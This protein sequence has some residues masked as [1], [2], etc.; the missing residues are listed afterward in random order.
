MKLS[1]VLVLLA[2]GASHGYR[3]TVKE[4][5]AKDSGENVTEGDEE[6]SGLAK[7]MVELLRKV[8]TLRKLGNAIPRIKT[9]IWGVVQKAITWIQ[10][11]AQVVAKDVKNPMAKIAQSTVRI[12]KRLKRQVLRIKDDAAYSKQIDNELDE[13]TAEE[14]FGMIKK[15]I[16][17][18]LLPE[19]VQE[20][21][22]AEEGDDGIH[23]MMKNIGAVSKG[24]AEVGVAAL[25]MNRFG[26]HAKH[27]RKAFKGLR[28]FVGRRFRRKKGRKNNSKDSTEDDKE[29]NEDGEDADHEPSEDEEDQAIQ[30]LDA[31]MQ[32][33]I[34]ESFEAD[35]DDDDDE[36]SEAGDDDDDEP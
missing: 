31:E 11:K 14:E 20:Q 2:F 10:K 32:K 21:E 23:H 30:S 8:K 27:L 26:A 13:V 22:E 24:A 5:F 25:I 15:G 35:E 12:A 36:P 1:V 18:I 16:K 4:S 34:E 17:Q 29:D 33:E 3:V 6:A 28:S 19:K 7:V 9:A